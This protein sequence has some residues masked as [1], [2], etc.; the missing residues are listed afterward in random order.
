[1]NFVDFLLT[2][3]VFLTGMY[4]LIAPVARFRRSSPDWIL[5]ESN[6]EEGLSLMSNRIMGVFLTTI[7]M[8]YYLNVNIVVSYIFVSIVLPAVYLITI[9]AMILRNTWKVGFLDFEP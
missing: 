6:R 4:H 9:K 5:A 1:M 2:F 8:L 3:P 7:T